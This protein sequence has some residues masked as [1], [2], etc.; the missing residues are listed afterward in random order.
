MTDSAVQPIACVLG[1]PIA[2]NPTQFAVERALAAADI[3]WRFLSLDVT[4]EDLPAAVAGMRAMGFRGGIVADPHRGAVAPLCDETDEAATIAAYVDVLSRQDDGPLRGHF[5]STEVLRAAISKTFADEAAGESAGDKSPVERTIAV[6][7]DADPWL[8]ALLPLMRQPHY[9]WRLFDTPPEL[10]QRSGADTAN[11]TP[12]G[13]QDDPAGRDLAGRDPAGRDPAG[14]DPAGRD[15]AG[16]DLAEVERKEMN[17]QDVAS[18]TGG[19]AAHPRR[20]RRTARIEE[21]I[22]EAVDVVLRGMCD[23]EPCLISETVI[24]RLRAP[25]LV[26]D[27][28]EWTGSS[29]LT[30]AAGKQ[31]LATLTRLDLMVDQTAR[32]VQCWTDQAIDEAIL[33]EAY[34]EFL[35][36]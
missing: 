34:E 3:D 14:R 6:L 36:I 5:V 30:R 32:A 12:D 11:S 28:A 8:A 19:N 23:G 16:R 29:P 10:W 2:G 25:A 35:E 4:A 27:L 1:H 21:T 7:G 18:P 24:Q 31:N 20:V 26:I 15:P 13:H 17:A 33:R 9:R 22:D